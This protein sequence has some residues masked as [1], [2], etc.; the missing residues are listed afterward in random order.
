MKNIKLVVAPLTRLTQT[1][2]STGISSLIFL[3][4]FL[5]LRAE[6]GFG[7]LS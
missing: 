4:L 6:A 3:L 5:Q 1:H 7:Q 2:F